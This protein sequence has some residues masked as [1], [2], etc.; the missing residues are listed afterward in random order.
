MNDLVL[1]YVYLICYNGHHFGP[2]NSMYLKRAEEASNF[3]L[4]NTIAGNHSPWSSIPE[5]IL[6]LATETDTCS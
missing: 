6:G 4:A 2:L 3:L 5:T 1:N